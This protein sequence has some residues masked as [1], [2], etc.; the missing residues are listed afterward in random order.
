MRASAERM[1]LERKISE[2]R[3]R[4]VDR[5]AD[6]ER[7]RFALVEAC[8]LAEKYRAALAVIVHDL[9]RDGRPNAVSLA[10]GRRAR[11][12]SEDITRLRRIAE[13]ES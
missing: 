1:E 3:T 11:G 2:L 12:P 4:L 10:W 13:G 6:A 7:L 9:D 8:D 5:A